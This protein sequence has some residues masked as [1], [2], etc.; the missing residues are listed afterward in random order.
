MRFERYHQDRFTW[1]NRR[2]AAYQVKCRRQVEALP[3]FADLVRQDQLDVDTERA[4][5]QAEWEAH[6]RRSRDRRAA[7]WREARAL[8]RTLPNCQ[9]AIQRWNR[10]RW[11]PGHPWYLLDFIHGISTGR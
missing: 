8:L 9:E 5:R 6:E 2:A 7:L 4:R 10:H 3:L 11:L 1:T